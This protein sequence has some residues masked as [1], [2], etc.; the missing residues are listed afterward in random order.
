MKKYFVLIA[1]VFTVLIAATPANAAYA[2]KFGKIQYD[3]PGSDNRSNSSL[4]A[5]WVRLWNTTGRSV[6]LTGWRLND[7]A[8]HTYTFSRFTLGPN[9][10]VRIHTGR[11]ANTASDRYWGSGNYIWNND[12]DTAALRDAAGH[13][14]DRCSWSGREGGS[15]NC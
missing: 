11:G 2:M 5:E 13:V 14:I 6:N 15:K 7:K 9:R 8:G 3:S 10:S 4:N 1:A 12:G